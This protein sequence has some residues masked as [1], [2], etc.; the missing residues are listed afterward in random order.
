MISFFRYCLAAALLCGL[1]ITARAQSTFGNVVG[2]VQDQTHATVPQ[3]SIKIRN[4]DDNSVHTTSS[5]DDGSFEV[6]NLKAGRYTIS[7]VKEGFTEYTVGSLQLDSRQTVR[8]EAA[9]TLASAETSVQI[10]D[11]VSAV[12]TE[13]ATVS[14]TKKFSQVVQLPMNYRGGNDSPLQALVAVPGVQQD[15]NGNISIGGG[16]PSQIQYSVDGAS[17]VNVRQNGALTNMNPSSELISELKVTQFNNNAEFSQLGDVT[18]TT[19]SGGNQIHGSGFEYLQNSV[20]DATPYGFDTKAHKAYNTFGG[21][22]SGPVVLPHVYKGKDRT[23]FFIDYEGN[24]RRFATPQQFSVPTLDMRNGDLANLPGGAAVDPSTGEPFPGN[25]IPLSQNQSSG[26]GA[27]KR[28]LAPTECRERYRYEREL[29]TA[30]ADTRRYRRIRH[31]D[32]SHAQREAAAVW[33]MELEERRY[34]HPE[35]DST[36]RPGSR[37]QS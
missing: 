15:S 20:L 21:S 19:K 14:D 23:F 36:E 3:A 4:L 30:P 8:L 25:K 18:I 34:H 31:P 28:I 24:R 13:N 16:T 2:T 5:A 10:S 27:V 11:A 17:T 33:A 12:N 37:N 26:E 1:A 32:R 7:I 29:S 6:L 9:L 22:L 35:R